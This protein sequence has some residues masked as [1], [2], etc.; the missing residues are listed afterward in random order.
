MTLV[1][2]LIVLA[3]IGTIMG[4]VLPNIFQS[5][6]DAN[7]RLART[8]LGKVAE[9]LARYRIDCRKLPQEIN[10]LVDEDTN[11]KNWDGPYVEDKLL[12]DPWDNDIMYEKQSGAK[13]RLYSLGADAEEG[14]DG[15]DKDVFHG[16]DD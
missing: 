11:C 12:V 16:E 8:Q 5:L 4:V 6:G 1:E 3:L 9:G 15:E 7:R 14:G 2:I 10:S 13:F